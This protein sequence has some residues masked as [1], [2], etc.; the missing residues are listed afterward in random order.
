MMSVKPV[1]AEKMRNVTVTYYMKGSNEVITK[2]TVD[3]PM[4]QKVLTKAELPGATVESS[5][6]LFDVVAIN[7][8]PFG[9]NDLGDGK[10]EV[11]VTATIKMHK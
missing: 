6:Y 1:A 4:S 2:A 7:N 3:V 5:G 8:G 11:A 9:I 10:G